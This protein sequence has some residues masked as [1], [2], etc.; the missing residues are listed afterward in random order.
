MLVTV[1]LTFEVGLRSYDMTS[2]ENSCYVYRDLFC[3]YKSLM[4]LTDR[5][6]CE[7]SFRELQ[8]ARKEIYMGDELYPRTLNIV[9]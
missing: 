5:E 1:P 3:E 2:Y 7:S 4:V 9:Y 6:T 8:L